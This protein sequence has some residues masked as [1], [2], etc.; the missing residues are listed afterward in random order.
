[1]SVN[2]PLVVTIS[3]LYGSGGA[4]LGQR[5]ASRLK[6]LFLDKELVQQAANRLKISGKDLDLYDEKLTRLWK[7]VV[8]R[9][10]G[11]YIPP[12]LTLPPD[13]KDL[14]NAQKD[15]ILSV[16]EQHS[17]VIVGR[18]GSYIYT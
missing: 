1:M 3:R 14:F 5:L 6:F 11:G 15:F 12:S 18:A 2:L 7:F 13:A 10:Y 4:Y 8:E 16:A 17:V 9:E